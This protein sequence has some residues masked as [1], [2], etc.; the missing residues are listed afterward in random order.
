M[1]NKFHASEIISWC[2]KASARANAKYL[3]LQHAS[4]CN[5]F[6]WKVLK[7]STKWIFEKLWLAKWD[8]WLGFLI[9]WKYQM[10]SDSVDKQQ[11]IFAIKEA[12]SFSAV[13]C[14][15][16]R[17]LIEMFDA[18]VFSV[19]YEKPIYGN[20]FWMSFNLWNK[21]FAEIVRKA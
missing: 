11:L 12:N 20:S 16:F 7:K 17:L 8:N 6:M 2:I 4:V 19:S 14:S 21:Q 18:E 3:I 15:S 10:Y 1:K 9:L 13:K 5:G